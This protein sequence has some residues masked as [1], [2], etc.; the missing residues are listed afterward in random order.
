MKSPAQ[1]CG[2]KSRSSVPFSSSSAAG[3]NGAATWEGNFRQSGG[4]PSSGGHASRKE[5]MALLSA[6]QRR[7]WRRHCH[8]TLKI[9]EKIMMSTGRRTVVRRA[10]Q[11]KGLR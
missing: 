3:S 1:L 4:A 6:S 10:G 2:T 9:S 8:I 5:P 7:Q 11:L